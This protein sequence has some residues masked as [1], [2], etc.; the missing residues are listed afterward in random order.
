MKQEEGAIGTE[1][2]NL[3]FDTLLT[4]TVQRGITYEEFVKI[5]AEEEFF[6]EFE[7]LNS[8]KQKHGYK[9]NVYNDHLIE[10]KKHFHLDN[11]AKNV[12]LKLDFEG[13]VLEDNG[14]NTIEKN[15]H[16]LLRN[17]LQ[18]S[19]SI[20]ELNELWNKNNPAS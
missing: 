15:V 14:R 2:L 3:M 13:N 12:H 16:K 20:M 7:Q 11:S 17:F 4:Q 6:G 9:F 18:Q 5:D 1:K 10:G 8:W 19:S